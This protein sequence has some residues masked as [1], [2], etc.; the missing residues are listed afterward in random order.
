[1]ETLYKETQILTVVL[2]EPKDIFSST[3]TLN[4][5]N[6]F[7]ALRREKWVDHNCWEETDSSQT[8]YQGFL[9]HFTLPEQAEG[10]FN[11]YEVDA[12]DIA[13]DFVLVISNNKV[14]GGCRILKDER[15]EVQQ[16]GCTR[17]LMVASR[18]VADS[19]FDIKVLMEGVCSYTHFR[20]ETHLF[21]DLRNS[22]FKLFRRG[23]L[24]IEKISDKP[25]ITKG[26]CKFFP[27]IIDLSEGLGFT[28][29]LL[30][31]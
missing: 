29:P 13:S 27:V 18:F 9:N 26:T 31:S 8:H 3:E 17:R 21:A 7:F 11:K 16:G 6:Q 14:V 2:I 1:M 30:R 22:L 5:V 12:Y 23:G 20:K 25:T 28:N 15:K 19:T 4:L 24:K 10:W